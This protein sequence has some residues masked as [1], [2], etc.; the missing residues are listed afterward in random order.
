MPLKAAL[1]PARDMWEYGFYAL[2][3]YARA[4]AERTGRSPEVVA[5][6]IAR[7]WGIELDLSPDS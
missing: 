5:N 6:V 1:D 3:V 2:L 4:A 7:R